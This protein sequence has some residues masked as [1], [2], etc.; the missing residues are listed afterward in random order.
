MTGLANEM[1]D[2]NE[3]FVSTIACFKIITSGKTFI[4]RSLKNNFGIFGMDECLCGQRTKEPKVW[5]KD[6]R[7]KGVLL[8]SMNCESTRS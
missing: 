8:D 3:V 5:P 7:T 2:N 4:D 1:M 6:Q